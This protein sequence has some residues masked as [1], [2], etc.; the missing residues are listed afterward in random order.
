[1][2]NIVHIEK[3]ITGGRGLAR[4]ADGMIVLVG[5]V[6]PGEKVAIRELRRHR[7]Y[8]E[9]EATAILE[10]SPGRCEPPCP[11]Y[12][13]CGGC[14]LQH[15]SIADQ[16]A[17]KES[18]VR[19]SLARADSTFSRIP[20]QPVIGAPHNFHYRHKIRLKLSRSG[21]LGFFRPRSN[22]LVPITSCLLAVEGLNIALAELNDS[23]LP[24][25]I[26]SS[27]REIELLHSPADGRIHALLYPD[28]RSGPI[29]ERQTIVQCGGLSRLDEIWLMDKNGPVA[30]QAADQPLLRQ[31]FPASVMGIPYS[32]AWSPGCFF[33]VNA[34]QNQQLVR[35]VCRMAGTV[36]ELKVLDLY[37]GTGN[38]SIPL[39]LLGARVTGLERSGESI[40]R[41]RLNAAAQSLAGTDFRATD[42]N[43]AL[44]QL[45]RRGAG[46]DLVLLDPP[47]QGV[48]RDILRLAALAPARIIYISCDPATLARDLALLATVDYRPVSLV[49]L[50]MFPQTHHVECMVL[51]EKI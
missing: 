28:L 16:L 31:D 20:Q 23:A 3:I 42:V 39:G 34:D 10:P 9:A 11:V 33:Q 41:A 29:P 50:D 47:R 2:Q 40:R 21:R 14:D 18:M 1:M 24:G 35:E 5:H 27:I 6:L 12:R 15:A 26:A 46:F 45:E 4:L 37:C 30:L 51:L 32:L 44:R 17:M 43:T 49:P 13:Q 25:A 7:G 19:E 22:E 36:R 8:I 48:G 38:F